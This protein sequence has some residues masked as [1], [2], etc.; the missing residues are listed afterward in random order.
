MNKCIYEMVSHIY[1]Y[2]AQHFILLRLS[3]F[4]LRV[5]GESTLGPLSTLVS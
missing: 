2:M 5:D 3:P 1:I 4:D